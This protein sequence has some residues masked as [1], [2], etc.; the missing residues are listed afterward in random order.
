MASI[1]EAERDAARWLI[2][3]QEDPGDAE[4]QARFAAWRA[5]SPENALAWAETARVYEGIG[6]I[7]P[8]HRAYWAPRP[9]RRALIAAVALALAACLAVVMLP[10]VMLRLQADH[11]TNTAE[12]RAV[13][14]PDGSTVRL[15][16]ASAIAT[17][18][19]GNERRVRLLRGEAF[20]EVRPDPGRPFRVAARAVEATVVGT[21]FEVRLGKAV[22]EIGVR[23]GQVRL[24]V[25]SAAP[26]VSE[27][28][29]AGQWLRIAATG[30]VA[31]GTSPT[32]QI[33]PWLNGQLIARDQP[34]GEVVDA[35]RPYFGGYILLADDELAARPLTGVYNLGD[36]L[37][38]I[39]AIASGHG[40]TVRE[41]SPWLLVIANG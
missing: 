25:A 5:A 26:P 7:A 2:A 22:S 18:F 15:G 31:R 40:A 33:A 9:K 37:A 39:R 38:A 19:A 29:T 23:E 34:L 4:L 17:A 11:L 36:P 21:A 14:L 10:G 6:R 30:A 24:D 16:P 27:R 28:L 13:T 1:P 12:L 3:L 20:F 32:A 41:I 35:L 8:Q